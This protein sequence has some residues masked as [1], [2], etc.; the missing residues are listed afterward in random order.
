VRGCWGRE[1]VV[2]V[3]LEPV[4]GRIEDL[5]ARTERLGLQADPE[6]VEEVREGFAESWRVV[7]ERGV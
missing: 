3:V 1:K 2:A 4:A 6:T 7:E 5:T